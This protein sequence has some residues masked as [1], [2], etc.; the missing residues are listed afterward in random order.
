M[1]NKIRKFESEALPHLDD[2][3]ST[4]L[5]MTGD[6]YIAAEKTRETYKIAFQ[7]WSDGHDALG[8]R[9]QLFKTFAKI[10]IREFRFR[11][12]KS[13]TSAAFTDLHP[14][15]SNL[16]GDGIEYDGYLDGLFSGLG[17]QEIRQ[18][19]LDLPDKL[20]LTMILSK[21]EGFTYQECADI[22]GLGL[23]AFKLRLYEACTY[24]R[25]RLLNIAKGHNNIYAHAPL[26]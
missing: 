22:V 26:R 4:A 8:P 5:W 24:L 9:V 2:L 16:D 18:A 14:H 15:S 1:M 25:A 19:V 21:L 6:E 7:Y 17:P 20:K 23:V 10:Y 11:Y 3:Y 12:E 13:G